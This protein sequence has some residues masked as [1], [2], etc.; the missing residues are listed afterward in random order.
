MVWIECGNNQTVRLRLKIG[1]D[2]HDIKF[3]SN[4]KANIAEEVAEQA[5]DRFDR[6]NY[7]NENAAEIAKEITE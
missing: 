5:I 6:L 4:G 3:T 2:Y 1:E 7:T